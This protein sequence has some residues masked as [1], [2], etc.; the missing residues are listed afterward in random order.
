MVYKYKSIYFIW[1]IYGIY[2]YIYGCFQT[3]RGAPKSSILMGF[4]LINHSFSLFLET[5]IH[6]YI[7]MYIFKYKRSLHNPLFFTCPTHEDIYDKF[8]SSNEDQKFAVCKFKAYHAVETVKSA[9]APT[10]ATVATWE[11]AH[12]ISK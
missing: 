4:S 6:I 3:N 5:P 8:N 7:Y 9:C 10:P 1:Y 12:S 2:I 11:T